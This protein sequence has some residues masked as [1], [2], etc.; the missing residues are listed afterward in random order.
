MFLPFGS[1]PDLLSSLKLSAMLKKIIDIRPKWRFRV[2]YMSC[3]NHQEAPNHIFILLP[4]PATANTIGHHITKAMRKAGLNAMAYWMRH[5]DA[6]NLLEAGVSI[7][8][9]KEMLG[10]DKIKSTKKYLRVHTKQMRQVLFDETINAVLYET[11][12]KSAVTG[13][14]TRPPYVYLLFQSLQLT[15]KYL[16]AGKNR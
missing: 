14:V 7:F 8:E 9:I 2:F 5:T 10:H 13:Y 6:Q 1:K 15:D 3:R 12:V 16:Q 4:L 11:P